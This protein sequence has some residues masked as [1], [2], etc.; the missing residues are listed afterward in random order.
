MTDATKNLHALIRLIG[1]T[2]L[3]Q[4]MNVPVGTVHAWWRRHSIPLRHQ[5]GL[6]AAARSHIAEIEAVLDGQLAGAAQR[7]RRLSQSIR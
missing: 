3:G 7:V 1:P 2:E 6:R 4:R 5:A